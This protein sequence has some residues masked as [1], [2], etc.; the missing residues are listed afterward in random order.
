MYQHKKK[1]KNRF[2]KKRYK[3][4][5]KKLRCSNILQVN[6]FKVDNDMNVIILII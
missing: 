3:T 2:R 1:E 4:F 6:N 5:E